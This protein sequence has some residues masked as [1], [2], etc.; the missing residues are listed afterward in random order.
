[1][2]NSYARCRNYRPNHPPIQIAG[3]C[4]AHSGQVLADLYTA[5]GAFIR[6]TVV[7]DTGKDGLS[8]AIRYCKEMKDES[9]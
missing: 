9:K 2:D 8:G 3:A 7:A 1:M 6:T 4:F 5:M